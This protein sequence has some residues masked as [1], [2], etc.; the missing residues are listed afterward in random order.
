MI[1]I[2]PVDEKDLLLRLRGG[3]HRAFEILYHQ[4]S[5]LLLAKLDRKFVYTEDA[6]DLLQELFVKIWER[7]QQIDPDQPFAGY[8]YRIAQ[9]MV[10]DHYRKVAL[11]N[12]VWSE[13]KRGASEFVEFTDQQV[14]G[15]ETQK[16]IEQAINIL[17]PQQQ[18]AFNLCKIEGR[19]YKEAAEIMSI[20]PETV[21]AHLVKANQSVKAYFQNAQQHIPGT[22]AVALLFLNCG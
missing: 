11:T 20:S 19:S 1:P 17:P 4:H 16:L 7:R 3:D 13:V 6:D 9:R 22:L 15:R 18:K 8:L 5:R 12:I 14:E 2:A 10:T 21:H